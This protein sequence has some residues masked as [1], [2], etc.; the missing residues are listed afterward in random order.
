MRIILRFAD[1]TANRTGTPT[2]TYRISSLLEVLAIIIY[3]I[4]G[5]N[6]IQICLFIELKVSPRGASCKRI[7]EFNNRR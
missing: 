4:L 6:K 1:H 2:Y 3:A 5:S 7:H